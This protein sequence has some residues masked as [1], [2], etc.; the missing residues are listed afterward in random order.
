MDFSTDNLISVDAIISEVARNIDD[1]PMRKFSKGYLTSLVQQAL[2]QLDFQTYMTKQIEYF[3][4][5]TEIHIPENAWNIREIYLFNGECC[6]ITSAQP[7]WWKANY[8]GNAANRVTKNTND[9]FIR[10]Y[11]YEDNVYYYNAEGGSIYFSSACATYE[12]IMV[13]FNGISTTIGTTP[14]IPIQWRR[15][16][17]DMV[18]V[19]CFKKLKARLGNPKEAQMYRALYAEAYNDLYNKLSGSYWNVYTQAVSMNT[20]DRQALLEYMSKSNE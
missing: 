11:T 15:V 10:S 20:H 17:C 18:T 14:M 8:R 12:K 13:V 1:E 2:E 4:Y 16:V 9:P 19:E 6:D 7:V 3:D 5:A